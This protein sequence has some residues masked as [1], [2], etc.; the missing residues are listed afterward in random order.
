M[1]KHK[2]LQLS[3][4]QE[5]RDLYR[6][7]DALTVEQRAA[8]L[9]GAMLG[10]NTEQLG[11]MIGALYG[12]TEM[13]E[14]FRAALSSLDEWDRGDIAAVAEGAR[15]TLCWPDDGQ[16]SVDGSALTFA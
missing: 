14:I 2:Q 5:H 3:F 12:R 15:D 1:N 9:E 4:A 7:A 11:K 16:P 13:A 8:L 6:M 10:T